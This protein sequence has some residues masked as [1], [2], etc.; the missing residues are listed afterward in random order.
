[1]IDFNTFIETVMEDPNITEIRF[2]RRA[3]EPTTAWIRIVRDDEINGITE[4]ISTQYGL[5]QREVSGIRP[6][7]M[8]F[9]CKAIAKKM[10]AEVRAIADAKRRS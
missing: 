4:V 7:D 9:Y 6:V 3:H 5:T 10:L 8:P 1:M 2:S